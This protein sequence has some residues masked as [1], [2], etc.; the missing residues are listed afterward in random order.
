MADTPESIGELKEFIKK[1]FEVSGTDF[2]NAF[3]SMVAQGDAIN[4]SF[5]QAR[6]RITE[7]QTAVVDA[8][9][10]VNRLGGEAKNV[11]ETINQIAEASRRN[12]VGNTKDIEKLFATFKVTGIDVK[13]LVD[14]FGK[15][16]VGISQIGT[17][18]EK[19][20]TYIQSIGGNTKQVMGD[21]KNSIEQM[22]RYQFEGGV[23]G[24]TKMAAQASMLRFDMNE[25]FRLADRVLDPDK[26]VEV[27]SAF[28]R[29]GV[30]AGALADPFALMNQ[31]INDPQGLQTSLANVAKQFTE[32]DEKTKT[33][34]INPQGVL[35]LREMENQT[36]VSAREMSKMAVAAAELDKRISDV[37]KA[38][39]KFASEEDKQY[40]ANIAKMGETG[41]YEV[42]LKDGTKKEL[43]ELT[44]PE[45]DKLIEA[46]KKQPKDMESIAR[47]QMGLSEIIKGDVAAIKQALLGGLISAR[48]LQQG[49]EGARRGL[50]GASGAASNNM[51]SPKA[52]RGE[53]ETGLKDIGQLIK[54]LQ[55][56][57][58]SS[59]DALLK[60]KDALEKQG[61]GIESKFKDSLLKTIE[62]ARQNTTDE[63]GIERVI[64]SGYD[65][66]LEK[67]GGVKQNK[68][69]PISSLIEGNKSSQQSLN[70]VKSV[71]SQNYEGNKQTIT[72]DGSVTFNF[73]FNGDSAKNLSPSQMEEVTKA[74]TSTLRS[75]DFLQA[76]YNN[77]NPGNP[78]KAPK[79]VTV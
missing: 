4:K 10:R 57:K 5:G 17:E 34:K 7:F 56:N 64:K 37:N 76:S 71:V 3:S 29:L 25:T 2:A 30:S 36:G 66:I 38:G 14:S 74:I 20:V 47:A 40:L 65:K 50:T 9:P 63:T 67:T 41:K 75:T 61:A 59:T 6:A 54:D 46:Q 70:N 53:V 19:S 31:S 51:A 13:T 12:V 18:L 72:H 15:V 8:T 55:S 78:T 27:A 11:T 69:T 52:I 28:Q 49:M 16:G 60:Y 79:N 42:E 45:F 32:F 73:N 43:A 22:N 68:N 1:Q 35:T 48:P 39:L 24:L 21:V 23:V 33:F 62:E 77:A 58:I 26:A 44:Q